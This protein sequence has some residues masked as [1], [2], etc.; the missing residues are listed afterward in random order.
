MK[1]VLRSSGMIIL[2]VVVTLGA[3]N[4]NSIANALVPGSNEI[5]SLRSTGGQIN[6]SS[7]TGLISPDG[8]VVVFK[9]YGLNATPTGGEGIYARNLSSGV[10][11]RV[12]VSTAGVAANEDVY[13][14]IHKI[15]STGRYIAF[16]SAATNLIDGEFT[17]GSP[18]YPQVY[19]RDMLTSTTTLISRAI[20]GG[21]SNASYNEIEGISS[22]GR[23]ILY[24]TIATNFHQDVTVSGHHLYMIDRSDDSVTVLDR[25][26]NGE[27]SNGLYSGASMSCDGS[28][29]AFDGPQNLIVGDSHSNH[30][31]V[32]LLDRRGGQNKLTNLTKFASHAV[33]G[34]NISCNGDF[35]SFK[36]S[37]TNLD[38]AYSV[39]YNYYPR[40]YIYDRV[41]QTF[42]LAGV[43]SLGVPSGAALCGAPSM[44]EPCLQLSDTGVGVF[45]A[46][47]ATLTGHS[48]AQVYLRN[49]R[50]NTT[51]L[52]SKNGS[53][54]GNGSSSYSSISADG[55]KVLFTS[56][57]TNLTASDNNGTFDMFIGQTGL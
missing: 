44:A 9:T 29:I 47:D 19:L 53:T 46:N 50:N 15:S 26:T 35:L 39:S 28:L 40:P 25:R 11:A 30:A 6:G 33:M 54:V 3:L 12:N 16:S 42:H 13:T 51:E 31:E 20:G 8:Q 7:S 18:Q 2:A 36:S 45:S 49:I 41:N 22:D 32:Y 5:A 21:V 27:I 14:R 37:G 24:T 52:L 4:L 34:P 23:F 10:V 1:R 57:S 56:G 17:A 55:R 38:P 43:T 48:G